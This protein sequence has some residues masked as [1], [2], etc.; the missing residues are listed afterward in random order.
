[1]PPAAIAKEMR[2][3]GALRV[4]I[5][6]LAKAEGAYIIASSKGSTR[7]REID[8]WVVADEAGRDRTTPIGTSYRLA[9]AWRSRKGAERGRVR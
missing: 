9:C 3:G 4:A 2:Q 6:G 8:C 5:A 7:S 1:M